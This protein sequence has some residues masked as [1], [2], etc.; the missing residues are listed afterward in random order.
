MFYGALGVQL[1]LPELAATLFLLTHLRM[2]V[3]T[4]AAFQATLILPWC[5]KP[6]FGLLS[7]TYPL[8]GGRR[9]APYIV[10]GNVVLAAVWTALA[11]IA[12]ADADVHV[13]EA[14]LLAASVATC[15]IDVMYDSLLVV[16][17]QR[18]G[19]DDHG[20]RQ[21]QCWA[22]R[23]AGALVSA[24][25]GGAL[26]QVVTPSTVF[27]L[28]ACVSVG[29]GVLA[30]ATLYVDEVRVPSGAAAATSA[31][32]T[33]VRALCRAFRTPA[34]WRPALFVFVFAATPSS[35]DA[36]FAF[37]VQDLHFTPATLGMLGFVRHAAMLVGTGVF[38]RCCRFARYRRF[39]ALVVVVSAVLGAT[40]VVL[41]THWNRRLG[42]PNVFFAA[43]DDLFLSVVGQIA[44]MPILI[45]A[46]KLAPRGVE[47]G[48]YASFVSVL[49]FAGLVSGYG[50]AVLTNAF[51]VTR[52][53][54]TRL[55]PLVLTCTAT[56][57]LALLALPLLPRGNVRDVVH[58]TA[59]AATEARPAAVVDDDDDKSDDDGRRP[60]MLLE[61]ASV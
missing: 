3:A 42:I 10:L 20:S 46:A 53:N 44:L 43:G 9:R 31:C 8:A 58:A 15:G 50:G 32:R 39:F 37:L 2:E 27:A 34:L 4:L 13:V 60:L 26:L 51:G 7:D 40:P 35:G 29:T 59:A 36:L 52:D 30:A 18:E 57:L 28:V 47:A 25:A 54:F 1:Q 16:C 21:A 11:R 45:L 49:N 23:A 6:L 19:P 5:L 56:S 61:V 41:V 48:L 17:T 22:A 55:M 33:R 38:Y 12:H 14:L 24:A